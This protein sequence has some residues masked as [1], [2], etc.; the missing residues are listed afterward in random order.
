MLGLDDQGRWCVA[1]HSVF[2]EVGLLPPADNPV[3]DTALPDVIG[4]I[5][6]TLLVAHFRPPLATTTTPRPTSCIGAE[7]ID[8]LEMARD[9]SFWRRL[10]GR[11]APWRR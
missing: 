4:Q 11:F 10:F 3:L 1:P 8:K 2:T 9:R 5:T 6:P 7:L